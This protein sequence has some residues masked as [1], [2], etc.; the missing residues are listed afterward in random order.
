MARVL[1]LF[2]VFEKEGE[3]G[4]RSMGRGKEKKNIYIYRKGVIDNITRERE[5]GGGKEKEKEKENE[6]ILYLNV[7]TGGF[8]SASR[9]KYAV[10]NPNINHVGAV[11]LGFSLCHSRGMCQR[12]DGKM[13]L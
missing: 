5:R 3:G 13:A 8:K 1:V 7:R 10:P 2:F 4:G 11:T 9:V 6:K 12:H